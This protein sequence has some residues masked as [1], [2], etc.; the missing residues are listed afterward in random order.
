M[1]NC[2]VVSLFDLHGLQK[3]TCSDFIHW[4]L[5]DWFSPRAFPFTNAASL[6]K[7]IIPLGKST[8][9]LVV[10]FQTPYKMYFV[11]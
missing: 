3:R 1:F 8:F 4:S 10:P 9:L 11:L 6:M 5:S 2:H 7:Q